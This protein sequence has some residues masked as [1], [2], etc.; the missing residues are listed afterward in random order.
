MLVFFSSIRTLQS[1]SSSS[2]ANENTFD[3]LISNKLDWSALSAFLNLTA[4]LYPITSEIEDFADS[5]K[6]PTLGF[7][8]LVAGGPDR[9]LP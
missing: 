7:P 2:E 9:P 8:L 1:L 4:S 5:G 6:F 3:A